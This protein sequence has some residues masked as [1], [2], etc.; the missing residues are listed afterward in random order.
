[1]LILSLKKLRQFAKDESGVIM[2][3]FLIVLP[4]MTWSIMALV[5]WWDTWRTINEGQK[6]AYAVADLVSR[7]K[8]VDMNFING[9]ETVMAGLLDRPDAISM[10]ITS[11]RWIYDEITGT[12]R[13]S[14][15]FS[16]SPFDKKTPLTES[17]VNSDISHLIPVMNSGESTVILET[18]TKYYPAF[19]VGI[20]VSDFRNFIVTKPRF[21]LSVCL[22]E[23]MTP[24]ESAAS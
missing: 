19:D 7:Q 12:G 3:E 24:C 18:W 9:M 17:Y 21:Y 15:I 23:N 4:L 13:Y 20:P 11:V 2:T 5:V 22:S 1:M 16:R 10:R 8:E 14:L 6:A